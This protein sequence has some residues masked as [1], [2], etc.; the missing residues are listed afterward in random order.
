MK[1]TAKTKI[2]MVIGDPVEH[3]L[4]PRL[5]NAG[6]VALHLDDHYVYVACHVKVE[7]I[8]NFVRGIRAMNIRGVSCTMPHKLAVMPYLDE[9]DE[10][11]KKIGAVNTIVN[12][13]G[14]LTGYNTDWLGVVT[15]L[16]KLTTLT[17]KT[18]ALLGA[19]GA[20]RAAAYAVTNK[21]AKLTIYNRTLNKA[22]ELAKEFYAD[23]Y[24]L[25][26]IEN[27]ASA[28]IIINTTSVGF[29]ENNRTV[30]PKKHIKDKHIVFDIVYGKKTQLLRDAEEKG[31]KIILGNEMFFHQGFPQFK[32]YTG[33][34]AP[35]EAMRKALL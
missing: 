33:H 30:L 15:P 14:K 8:E 21:G 20:A 1:I 24:S 32:L 27:I 22:Q 10:V 31:A 2:C 11:A 35:Q 18:V 16:E 25:E 29:E 5:H 19:G 28:D 4:S 7:N 3:S 17:N 13:E 34:D 6:Y 26:E 23:A 9:I 12:E